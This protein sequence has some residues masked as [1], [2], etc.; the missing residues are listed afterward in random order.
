MCGVCVCVVV[1]EGV[2]G[3]CVKCVVVCEGGVKC[4][5]EGVCVVV[6]EGVCGSV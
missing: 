5:S 2:C 6:C 1:C 4:G 3:R